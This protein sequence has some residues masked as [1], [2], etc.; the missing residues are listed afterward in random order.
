MAVRACD[1]RPVSVPL[2]ALEG[3]SKEFHGV[4]ALSDASLRVEPNT[5]HALLGENGAGKT[6]L[7]RI[8]FGL[9]RPDQGQIVVDGQRVRFR[10]PRDAMSAGLGMVHQHFTLVQAMTVAENVALGLPG[11]FNPG[12]SRARVAELAASVGLSTDA[13]RR[14]ADLSIGAQQRVEI[15]K[16]IA[17][18]ARLLILDEPTAVLPPH[19]ASE[20]LQWVRRFA[21]ENHAVILITH[22]LEEVRAIAD[23]VSVLRR[24][25]VVLESGTAGLTT[26]VL[27]H[28]MVGTSMTPRRPKL[29]QAPT[30]L[31]RARLHD[32]SVVDA[33]GVPRLRNVNLEV[34]AQ[35]IVGVVGV[36]GAGHRELLRVLAGRQRPSG[37]SVSVAGI[38]AFI[39]E[40]RL[41]DAV[42]P[43][44]DLSANYALRDAAMHRGWMR[45]RRIDTQVR[46]LLRR[47]D[48]R[49]SGPRS[50]MSELSGGNQQKFVLARELEGS[51]QLLVAENPMRGL[52]VRATLALVARLEEARDRGL[53][54]VL[55]SSD[56]DEVIGL[57]DRIMVMYAGSLQ[58]VGFDRDAIGRAMTGVTV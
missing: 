25:R 27:V 16:A 13:D 2:L 57:A 42:L 12:V 53:A 19:E 15:L 14:I 43:S 18:Q 26:D 46:Q 45:W 4:S 17:G 38:V 9:L 10:S 50:R 8:A 32:V 39:P 52:D 54:V 20:L 56:L 21:T 37:G 55:Y 58:D 40:D 51:P 24:G 22:K 33:R 41:R 23:R 31:I 6:T 49:A 47:H 48:I 7:M 35:E 3:V 11:R 34:R 5:V 28:A 36:E 44:E 30:P 1:W 29:P